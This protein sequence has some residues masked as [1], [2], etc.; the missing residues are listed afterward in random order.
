MGFNDIFWL[1]VYLCL[2][3]WTPEV[4]YPPLEKLPVSHTSSNTSVEIINP[5]HTMPLTSYISVAAKLSF[6]SQSIILKTLN[7]E[8]PLVCTCCTVRIDHNSIKFMLRG[9]TLSPKIHLTIFVRE[10]KF[11]IA[12]PYQVYPSV[13]S[14]EQEWFFL[15]SVKYRMNGRGWKFCEFRDNYQSRESIIMNV[16]ALSL[17]MALWKHCSGFP[18][19]VEWFVYTLVHNYQHQD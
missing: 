11:K 7:I 5:S 13:I 18:D 8:L 14:M 1:P 16:L 10:I 9:P 17:I 6:I 15:I 12:I 3:I 19:V 4:F 2:N